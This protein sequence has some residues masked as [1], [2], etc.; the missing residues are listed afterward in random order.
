MDNNVNFKPENDTVNL[1]KQIKNYQDA[2]GLSIKKLNFGLWFLKKR[3]LF[4]VI[5]ISFLAVISAVCWSYTIYGFAYYL[6]KGMN[7]DE[8]LLR[9]MVESNLISHSV[10]LRQGAQN[11]NYYSVNIFPL[12]DERYDFLS[13]VNN[14]NEDWWA[15][16]DYYFQV[17]NK[18]TSVQTGFIFPK[19]EKSLMALA[20]EFTYA[21]SRA[22]LVVENLRWRRINKHVIPNWHDFYESHTDM[23]ISDSSFV[24][25]QQSGLSEKINLN[26][27]DF[28]VKNKTAYNYWQVDF[29]ILLYSGSKVVGINRYSLT[30]FMSGEERVVQASWPG[31][32]GRINNIE[33]TPDI[34]IMDEN[35]YIKYEGG[36]G[37]EK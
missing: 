6:A 34:N 35:V 37:E 26:Q 11:L 30:D 27:L 24:L 2:E 1:E 10:A 5:L 7:E 14:P 19:E 29:N 33:I 4:R 3:D 18:N 8:V 9:Q 22:E 15:T 20:E 16:F 25:S 36:I 28:T 13:I 17:N 12:G 21:P 32:F 23:V 31:K